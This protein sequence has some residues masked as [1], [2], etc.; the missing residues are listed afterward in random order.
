M[1]RSD[2]ATNTAHGNPCLSKTILMRIKYECTQQTHCTMYIIHEKHDWQ[3]NQYLHTQ[4]G[5]NRSTGQKRTV[6][7]AHPPNTTILDTQQYTD[8][9]TATSIA[10]ASNICWTKREAGKRLWTEKWRQSDFWQR[11]H[12]GGIRNTEANKSMCQQ[13]TK[14]H[15]QKNYVRSINTLEWGRSISEGIKGYDRKW[16]S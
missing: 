16:I 14:F 8:Y 2:D 4:N 15:E 10:F 13:L 6:A 5:M 11:R 7:N 9:I 1:W 3:Q 12:G